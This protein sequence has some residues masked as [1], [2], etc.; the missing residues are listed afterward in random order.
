M[1]GKTIV[2]GVTGSIAAYKSAELLSLLIKKGASVHTVMTNAAT[3]F[4]APLT[5]RTISGNPVWYDMFQDFETPDVIHIS[6]A[7]KADILVIAPA[8]A[9]CLGKAASGIADDL[10]TTMIMAMQVPVLFVPAMNEAMYEN[11]ILKKNIGSLKAFGYN[12]MEPD[13]GYLACGREGKGRLPNPK[14]IV[15]EIDRILSRR[16]SLKGVTILVTAGP[17]Q[18][19]LDP[20]RYITNRSSGKMGYELAK[21]AQKRGADVILVTGP[22]ALAPPPAIKVINVRTTNEMFHAVMEHLDATDV[23]IGA[24]APADWRPS[25]VAPEKIKKNG[26]LD[27]IE[28]VKCEDI[29]KEIGIHKGNRI[30]I[31]L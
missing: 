29:M 13:F 10:L 23:I 12:V 19:P 11:P 8:S 1:K 20:V 9:N 14:A 17:T 28:L 16:A 18:E 6:L 25:Q 2:L 27:N 26:G 21:A 15:C 22:A 24:A 5:L 7:R 3:K 4:I 30:T 31:G